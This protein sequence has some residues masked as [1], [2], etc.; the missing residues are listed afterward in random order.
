[1]IFQFFKNNFEKKKSP[2]TAS[3]SLN[4]SLPAQGS[5]H[6]HPSSSHC[7]LSAQIVTG[8][9]AGRRRTHNHTRHRADCTGQCGTENRA[10]TGCVPATGGLG[11]SS[12]SIFCSGNS[13]SMGSSQALICVEHKDSLAPPLGDGISGWL[14]IAESQFT[15]L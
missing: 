6:R 12:K 11:Q 10:L 15:L 13:R 1:M 3:S 4:V 2:G 5:P 7:Q 9:C 14:S 8:C